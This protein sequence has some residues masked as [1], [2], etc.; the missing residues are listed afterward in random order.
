[1]AAS[2]RFDL[3][4]SNLFDEESPW[5][6]SPLAVA[7]AAAV[8]IALVWFLFDRLVETRREQQTAAFLDLYA[9]AATADD[10]LKVT[11]AHLDVPDALVELLNLGA[12]F[13]ATKNYA[14]AESAFALAATRFPKS[15]LAD[16]ALLGQA[17]ALRAQGKAD[18]AT[19]PLERITTQGTEA[20]RPAAFLALASIRREKND[21]AG[22]RQALQELI[23]K[24]PQSAF[25]P[26]A[27]EALAALPAS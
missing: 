20:Y 22:A 25:A 17:D 21:L 27:Q 26:R 9:A 6:R 23:A 11:Q 18:A 7:A 16:A 14:A 2:P 19:A 3:T 5:Y 8:V 13:S 12:S 10:K 4:D 24:Y 1:M 15:P